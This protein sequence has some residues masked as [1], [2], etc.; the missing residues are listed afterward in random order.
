MS[1]AALRIV[2]FEGLSDCCELGL[3]GLKVLGYALIHYMCDALFKRLCDFCDL[4]LDDL[5]FVLEVF[6]D[7]IRR[8]LF[9]SGWGWV[10]SSSVKLA[11]LVLLRLGG[12]TSMFWGEELPVWSSALSVESS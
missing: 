12:K 7:G 11:F 10:D 9:L 2:D 1:R 3:Y 4:L 8:G 5:N 6:D